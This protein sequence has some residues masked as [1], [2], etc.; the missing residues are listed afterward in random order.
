MTLW[1]SILLGIVQGVTEFLPISSSGH[2][3][4]A[5]EVL[6][7]EVANALLFDVLLH[8]ATLAAVIVY[9]REDI[10]RLCLT[11]V[12]LLSGKLVEQRDRVLLG[13]L[14][15]GTLP[16]ATAGFLWGDVLASIFRNPES[17]AW[18]LVGGSALFLAAEWSAAKKGAP[19]ELKEGE[20]GRGHREMTVTRG[21]AIGFYQV[22]ALIPG[23]SRSGATISG[24][25]IA[26][27]SRREAIRFSFLLAF[28]I[29]LGSAVLK[30]A[31]AAGGEA[32]V[33]AGPL[34][35]GSIAAFA[36]GLLA[37]HF[38][39]RYLEHHTFGVFIAYRL[40]LA[41]AVFWII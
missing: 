41:A 5:R 18:A 36:S 4:L 21:L 31:E 11:A 38:L 25:L 19:G 27:L 29:I 3:I 22:L 40:L 13:A 28:P 10:R 1:E 32:A 9:F 2:L 20:E 8:V 33:A 37:I 17:V 24:G 7:M 30:T 39:V 14:A 35:I 15:I 6:G 34:V 26:G 16:A 12:R 23:V